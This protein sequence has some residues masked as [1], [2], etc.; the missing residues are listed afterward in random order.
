M[1]EAASVTAEKKLG[2]AAKVKESREF[3][4]ESEAW[5][6]PPLGRS[7]L[8]PSHYTSCCGDDQTQRNHFRSTLQFQEG[9]PHSL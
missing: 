9:N 5:P 1:G 3:G 6:C 8:V 4:L 7:L 2:Q